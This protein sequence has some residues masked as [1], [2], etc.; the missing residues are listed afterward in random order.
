MASR[1]PLWAILFLLIIF[2][3][4]AF[5]AANWVKFPGRVGWTNWV[6]MNSLAQEGVLTTFDLLADNQG[7]D[8]IVMARDPNNHNK[9]GFDCATHKMQIYVGSDPFGN[10]D[11]IADA[12]YEPIYKVICKSR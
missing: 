1:M 4:Q 10:T 3:I 2:P 8:P 5:A 9:I 12:Q 7:G 6:D 11:P